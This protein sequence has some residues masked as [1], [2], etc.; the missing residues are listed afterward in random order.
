MKRGEFATSC[1][2][3]VLFL[4]VGGDRK[5]ERKRERGWKAHKGLF[6]TRGYGRLAFAFIYHNFPYILQRSWG[7][8]RQEQPLIRWD[9]DERLDWHA[10][11][12]QRSGGR[13]GVLIHFPF[14]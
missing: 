5:K 4:L 10:V 1:P 14:A 12:S 6:V 13:E 8:A 2:H 3:I 9:D 7:V 11:Q